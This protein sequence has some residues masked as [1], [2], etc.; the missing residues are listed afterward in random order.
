MKK[1]DKKLTT[2]RDHIVKKMAIGMVVNERVIDQV[3]THQFNS[4]EDAT[5][6]NNSIEI[7]ESDDAESVLKKAQSP[8]RML[9]LNLRIEEPHK[10]RSVVMA[11]AMSETK[12]ERRMLNYEKV[13]KQ[14]D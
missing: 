2:L 1:I 5:K 13:L 14:W 10:D 9:N 11:Q 6:T 8:L 7:S 3:I 12:D 4:A